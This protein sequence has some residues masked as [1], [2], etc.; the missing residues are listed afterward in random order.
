LISGSDFAGVVE[1]VGDCGVEYAVGDEVVRPFDD[2]SEVAIV[3]VTRA[4][5]PFSTAANCSASA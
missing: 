2:R 3:G 1:A 4:S 5:R